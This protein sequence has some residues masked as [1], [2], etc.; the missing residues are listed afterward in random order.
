MHCQKLSLLIFWF[1]G[2]RS[3]FLKTKKEEFQKIQI[4]ALLKVSSKLDGK[5]WSSALMG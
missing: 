5:K 1:I 3:K 4:G 2:L